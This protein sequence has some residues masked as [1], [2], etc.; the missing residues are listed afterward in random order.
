MHK[1]V[2]HMMAWS[3]RKAVLLFV[4]LFSVTL[5]TVLVYCIATHNNRLPDNN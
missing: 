1:Q 2:K 5:P 4:L 3:S